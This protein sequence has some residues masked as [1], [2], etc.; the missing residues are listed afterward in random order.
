MSA[1]DRWGTSFK[2]S[3]PNFIHP[4]LS[5]ASLSLMKKIYEEINI[6]LESFSKLHVDLLK[7]KHKIHVY[8]INAFFCLIHG[9]L[10]AMHNA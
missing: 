10:T 2:T 9:I 5:S 8:K 1:R 7:V 4:S 6:L 3:Q